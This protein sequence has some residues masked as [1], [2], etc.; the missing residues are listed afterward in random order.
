MFQ[1][2]SVRKK[3]GKK[4]RHCVKPLRIIWDQFDGR[5]G[6]HNTVHL[7]DLERNFALNAGCGLRVSPFRRGRR[8][9]GDVELLGLARYLEELARNVEDFRE[10]NFWSWMDVVTGKKGILDNAK[11]KKEKKKKKEENEG[12]L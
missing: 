6:E 1:I 10:V 8:G 12:A 11:K 2:T 4:V 9:R 5:W 3:D 7:D